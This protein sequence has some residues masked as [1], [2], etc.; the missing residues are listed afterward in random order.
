MR[1]LLM[2]AQL[3]KAV[4]RLVADVTEK[5]VQVWVVVFQSWLFFDHMHEILQY[6]KKQLHYVIKVSNMPMQQ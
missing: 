3:V 6:L 2:L 5:R 1:D 4:K